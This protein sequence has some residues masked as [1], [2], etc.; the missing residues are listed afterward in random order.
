MKKFMIY[1]L[2]SLGILSTASCRLI[3]PNNNMQPS[4]QEV[5]K[6]ATEVRIYG[7]TPQ[8]F[9]A[10]TPFAVLNST[11]FIN[12]FTMIKK[13]V[14]IEDRVLRGQASYF[15]V[16]L[17]QDHSRYELAYMSGT[18]TD[19]HQSA[20]LPQTFVVWMNTLPKRK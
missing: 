17:D 6:G 18:L 8:G 4:L 9:R 12:L 10:K 11:H 7:F 3:A 1:P 5:L 15:F 19:E 14:R 20:I 13:P 16:V 2:L